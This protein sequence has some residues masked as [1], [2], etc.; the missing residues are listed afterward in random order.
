MAKIRL[1]DLR[2]SL[3][4]G[5]KK[6]ISE[7]NGLTLILTGSE[8][9]TSCKFQHRCTYQGK[10]REKILKTQELA[11]ARRIALERMELVERGQDPD[12]EPAKEL[13][14]SDA[15][16]EYRKTLTQRDLSQNTREYRTRYSARIDNYFGEREVRTLTEHDIHDFI[17]SQKEQHGIHSAK[18]TLETF[19]LILRAAHII[20]AVPVPSLSG[21]QSL[22]Q[23]PSVVHRAALTEGDISD[24]ILK[25]FL[26]FDSQK[27]RDFLLLAFMLLMR[28]Q[29]L[30]SIRI[31]DVNFEERVLLIRKTKTLKSGF[32]IPITGRLETFLRYLIDKSSGP[33][34][35]TGS[36][37]Q[38]G[39]FWTG[40]IVTRLRELQVGQSI[41]GIRSVGRMWMHQNKI[42]FEVAE[43]CLTHVV[44]SAVTR[45]YLRTDYFDERREAL[46]KWHEF[47]HETLYDIMPVF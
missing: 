12:A 40:Q 35:I 13:T 8:K 22:F 43:S 17:M 2:L 39:R 19:S 34:L 37:S 18:L 21:M 41:H 24:N 42:P 14:V 31:D 46:E 27:H 30:C 28:K 26:S 47:L 5:E 20:H 9:G 16:S 44:G 23:A 33:Y 1:A 38:S 6:R 29:E 10:R 25:I 45:A 4:P 15:V 32:R 3:A 11:D 36:R 7:G